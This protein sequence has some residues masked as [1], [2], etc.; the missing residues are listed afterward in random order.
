MTLALRKAGYDAVLLDY[1]WRHDIASLGQRLAERIIVDGRD[2]VALVAHSMGGL[3]SRAALTHAAGAKVSQLI[4]LGTPNTGSLA[5]VQALRGTYSVV[6]KIAMLDLRH[7]A[8]YLARHVF[9][10][11]PGCTS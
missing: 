9:S 8:E 1:D 11:F 6:R 2:N 5:A 4:M 10:T 3:V 7:D